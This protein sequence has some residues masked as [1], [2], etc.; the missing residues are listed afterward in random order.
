[1]RRLL[2]VVFLGLAACGGD[3][4]SGEPVGLP[5]DT[6]EPFEYWDPA[7]FERTGKELMP[8][9][10]IAKALEPHWRGVESCEQ[11][12]YTQTTPSSGET[13]IYKLLF[14]FNRS[15][16]N[17]YDLACEMEKHGFYVS[18]VARI[19]KEVWSDYWKRVEP[20]L[21]TFFRIRSADG[22]AD[23]ATFLVND[24]HRD[25]KVNLDGCNHDEKYCYFLYRPSYVINLQNG[26]FTKFKIARRNRAEFYED[27]GPVALL[28]GK[29]MPDIAAFVTGEIDGIPRSLALR[30]LVREVQRQYPEGMGEAL[31]LYGYVRPMTNGVV[32]EDIGANLGIAGTDASYLIRLTDSPDCEDTDN[33]SVRHCTLQVKT[34]LQ[35]YNRATGSKQTKIAQIANVAAAG[36]QTGEIEALFV[37]EEGGWRLVVTE[38]IAR[39]LSGKDRKNNW[40]VRTADGRTL[41]GAPAVSCIADPNNC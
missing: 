2:F 10:G 14:S 4:S 23:F 28:L 9:E 12:A 24:F 36:T 17:T 34:S 27:S 39:F 26:L 32:I 5:R 22:R 1:M 31:D 33:P 21:F 3:S 6:H 41:M 40:A 25:G 35:A 16:G 7:E 30:A 19:R 38:E 29:E 8:L 13:Y 11:V 20:R 37:Q 18:H 15:T